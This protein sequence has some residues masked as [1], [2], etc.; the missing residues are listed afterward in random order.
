[1]KF[2]YKNVNKYYLILGRPLNSSSVVKVYFIFNIVSVLA[3]GLL[4]PSPNHGNRPF[5]R[6]KRL[7]IILSRSSLLDC[8]INFYAFSFHSYNDI[9]NTI[10]ENFNNRFT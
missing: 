6:Y 10:Y 7:N 9:V 8:P 4:P 2:L 1:M 3:E 5:A